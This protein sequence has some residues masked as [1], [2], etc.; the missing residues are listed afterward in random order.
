M[1]TGS[2]SSIEPGHSAGIG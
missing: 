2:R 1:A